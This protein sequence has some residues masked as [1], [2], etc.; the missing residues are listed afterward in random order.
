MELVVDD[1]EEK[2]EGKRPIS[3]TGHNNSHRAI[4]KQYYNKNKPP[5]TASSLNRYNS[6]L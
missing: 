6:R 3:N 4:I 5:P 2:G 1:G